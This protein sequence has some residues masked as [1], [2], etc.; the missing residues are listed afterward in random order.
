M[1]SCHRKMNH[2]VIGITIYI[3]P[4]RLPL[5]DKQQLNCTQNKQCNVYGNMLMTPFLVS[6]N[7]RC[8][9]GTNIWSNFLGWYYQAT[10]VSH[11]NYHPL[12]ISIRFP[13]DTGHPQSIN[14]P[15]TLISAVKRVLSPLR[16]AI[17]NNHNNVSLNVSQHSG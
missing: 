7:D 2:S 10:D 13:T 6:Q 3:D 17:V 5:H 9:R 15:F 16:H 1:A 12:V 8:L 14:S 4:C 11:S